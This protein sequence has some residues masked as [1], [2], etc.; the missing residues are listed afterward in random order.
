[1]DDHYKY[2]GT[3]QPRVTGEEYEQFIDEF[4]AAVVKVFGRY[5]FIQVSFKLGNNLNEMY[6]SIKS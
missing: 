5:T 2:V 1:M 6:F 4:M 3:L